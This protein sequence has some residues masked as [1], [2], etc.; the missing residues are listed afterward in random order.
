MRKLLLLVISAVLFLSR[1]PASAQNQVQLKEWTVMAYMNARNNLEAEGLRNVNQMELVGSTDRINILA[2]LGR[3]NGQQGDTHADGNWVGAKLYYIKRDFNPANIPADRRDQVYKQALSHISSPA[4]LQPDHINMG[5]YKRLIE[6]VRYVKKHYPA[7]HYA[8]IIWNHGSGIMDPKR[9]Y[10][11]DTAAN[12]MPAA[13][14]AR[15]VKAISID[16]NGKFISTSELA[17]ALRTTGGADVLAFDA[18]LMQMAEIDYE[19]GRY[20]K[21]IVGSQETEPADGYDYAAFLDLLARNPQATP[22][23]LGVFMVDTFTRYYINQYPQTH[24]GT[25]LSAIRT[26]EIPNLMRALDTWAVT[27]MQVND[28][29]ALEQGRRYSL[30]FDLFGSMDPDRSVSTYADLYDFI[31]VVTGSTQSPEL[32]QA[33]QNLMAQIQRT[34]IRRGVATGPDQPFD[35]RRAHGMSINLPRLDKTLSEA[36]V[37]DVEFGNSYQ[38]LPFVQVSKWGQFYRWMAGY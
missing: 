13:D 30:R 15:N 8:L 31:Y 9:V 3:T 33:G 17:D 34:I 20:A 7:K 18:C 37:E 12:D 35:Y 36:A 6:F 25:T 26:A 28:S 22:E 2:Y 10:K 23:Q 29:K 11:K 19:V 27:A 38:S 24:E 14:T 32:K 21:V 5:N 4:T 1:M 16:A